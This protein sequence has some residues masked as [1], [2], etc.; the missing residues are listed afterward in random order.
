M[1][2]VARALAAVSWRRAAARPVRARRARRARPA[3]RPRI[4]NGLDTHGY[5]TA[6][7]LLY[8]GATCDNAGTWCSGTLIGCETF[9]VAAH[10]VVD[11]DPSHY[12]VY[13]QHAGLVPVAS[14]T[15]HPSYLDADFPLFDVAVIK[16]GTG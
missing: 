16:L 4:V 8:G 13:L 3:A 15:R 5:P 10:C 1:R 14:I 6:G 12:L 2:R 11:L 7:A 9:L